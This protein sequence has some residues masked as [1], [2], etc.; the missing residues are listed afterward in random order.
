[1]KIFGI[2]L[3]TFFVHI[4][5]YCQLASQYTTGGADIPASTRI[6]CY[7]KPASLQ[8]EALP[9]GNG[10]IGGMIYGR[11]HEEIIKLNENTLYAGGPYNSNGP[12]GYPYEM[13]CGVQFVVRVH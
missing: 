6:L 11:V 7:D 8:T 2:I 3:I 9:V 10:R 12:G 5:S 1:M 4:F 13:L